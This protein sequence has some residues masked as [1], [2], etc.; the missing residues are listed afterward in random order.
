MTKS[1][2]QPDRLRRFA[3]IGLRGSG[4]TTVAR[5]LA[6]LI[7]GTCVDTDELVVTASGRSIAEIFATDGEATFRQLERKAVA[8]AVAG[9]ATVISVGG[10]AIL[11]DANVRL[12]KSAATVVWL[13]A[14]P[15]VLW[16]RI[17]ADSQTADSRP[18]LTDQT[19]LAEMGQLAAQRR[20][21]Y[22]AAAGVVIDTNGKTLAQVTAQIVERLGDGSDV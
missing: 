15:E 13:T 4:K 11:D 14:P 19:G 22:E 16:N 12:L 3:L 2:S 8:D 18:A 6:D 17:S 21:Y 10:G 5:L 20:P 7:G 9:P 1:T